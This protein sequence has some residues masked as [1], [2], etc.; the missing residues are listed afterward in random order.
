MKSLE[1]HAADKSSLGRS[2]LPLPWR[3]MEECVRDQERGHGALQ[4]ARQLTS[5]LPGKPRVRR[6]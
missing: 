3:E 5:E 2:G 6:I 1:E 4:A